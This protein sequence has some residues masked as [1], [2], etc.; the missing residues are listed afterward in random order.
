VRITGTAVKITAVKGKIRTVTRTV[1]G[2]V[3]GQDGTGPVTYN[4]YTGITDNTD[5]IQIISI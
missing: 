4:Q 3:K 2:G 1:R 5:S